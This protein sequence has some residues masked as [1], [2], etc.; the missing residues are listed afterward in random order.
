[1]N[2]LLKGYCN[3]YAELCVGK[4]EAKRNEGSQSKLSADGRL[5][6]LLDWDI[7]T[8]HRIFNL[9]ESSNA[10]SEFS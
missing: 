6:I 3:W 10:D 7:D 1:M 2:L 8:S 4:Q 5:W 9:S